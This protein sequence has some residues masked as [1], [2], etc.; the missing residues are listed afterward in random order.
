[1]LNFVKATTSDIDTIRLL[2]HEIWTTSYREML[3]SEQMEYMLN[4]MYSEDTIKS[5][6]LG[7]VHWEIVEEDNK[8][9]GYIALTPEEDI[10]KLNK[11]YILS[12]IQ[13][14]GIGQLA[15]NHVISYGKENG[16]KQVYLTVNQRNFRAIKA[17]EKA[18][19]IRTDYKVFDI[20]GGFIM[21]DYIY[22][23]YL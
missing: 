4:W 7:N 18:G 2:A 23:F 14:K 8:P 13:G 6:I 20:G 15:L 21:D 5:E 19:F 22:T 1:M 9:I 12:T 10:L 17:Y 16:F 3:S 11:L